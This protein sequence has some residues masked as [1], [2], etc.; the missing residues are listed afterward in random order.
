MNKFT[1]P[2]WMSLLDKM[3]WPIVYILIILVISVL[4]ESA[5][6]QD[7]VTIEKWR[8][9]KVCKELI[10]LDSLT[11]DYA[12]KDS[13][14][15]D[16]KELVSTLKSQILSINGALKEKTIQVD[17]LHSMQD[18]YIRESNIWH[19]AYKKQK[20]ARLGLSFGINAGYSLDG[21]AYFGP[22]IG[23]TYTFY[24]L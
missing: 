22:G 20:K 17:L 1:E 6:A 3:F 12:E 24:K 10:L 7:L 11:K 21:R 15:K 9:E 18:G 23:A 14:N 19:N 16:L 2:R 8:L 4:A 13:I 5:K